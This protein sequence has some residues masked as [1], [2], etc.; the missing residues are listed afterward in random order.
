MQWVRALLPLKCITSF[1][2]HYSQL[3]RVNTITFISQLKNRRLKELRQW[4]RIR[5][6]TSQV[7]VIPSPPTFI[8]LDCLAL[9][10]SHYNLDWHFYIQPT[11]FVLKQPLVIVYY[12]KYLFPFDTFYKLI[13]HEKILVF[14]YFMRNIIRYYK[15]VLF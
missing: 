13:P 3:Y 7:R 8:V 14:W 11:M 10:T 15:V 4:S 12:Y 6:Y 2:S 9:I 5:I 1:N